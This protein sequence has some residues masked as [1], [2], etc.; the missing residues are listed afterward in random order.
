MVGTFFLP[1]N[2]SM[3]TGSTLSP[4]VIEPYVRPIDWIDI[5]TV[6]NNEINLLV[7]DGTCTAFIVDIASGTYNID[8]GDGVIETE[9]TSGTTYQHE[10]ALG[11]GQI[12]SEGYTTYKIRIYGATGN[13]TRF[14]IAKHSITNRLQTSPILW[15]V[16]GTLNITSY[17]NAFY[18]STV[19]ARS[20]RECYIPSFQSTTSC[21]STFVN[22]SNLAKITIPNSWGAV[23]TTVSMFNNC[24]NLKG[25][26]LPQSWGLITSTLNMFNNCLILPT[27]NLPVTWGLVTNTA[28]MF[29]NCNGFTSLVLPATWGSITNT[30]SMF[31]ACYCLTSIKMPVSW[32]LISNASSM[33]TNCY[34]LVTA[35]CG[36]DWGTGDLTLTQ[37]F[38]NCY[39]LNAVKLPTTWGNVTNTSYM[40]S[41]CYSLKAI[42]LPSSWGSINA[43]NRM[44]HSCVTLTSILLPSSWGL[45]TTTTYMFYNC[46][47]LTNVD[48]G[49][50]WGAVTTADYMFQSCT[51]LINVK[52]PNSWGNI[53]SIN[54]MFYQCQ[55]LI[56]IKFGTS[57]GVMQLTTNVFY[58]CVNL[59]KETL[60]TTPSAHAGLISVGNM[61][62][63]CSS[64]KII[65]NFE[66]LKSASIGMLNLS[67]IVVNCD[68]LE[69]LNYS[70]LVGKIAVNGAS[71]TYPNRLSSLRLT[72]ASSTF[73]GSS[74]QVNVS[75]TN[76]SK[77]ALVTLFGDLP[78]LTSKTINITGAVGAATL[79]AE[80]RTIAT[81]K[82][83]TIIG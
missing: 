8:W 59:V 45:I 11:G 47:N 9:R 71:V 55:G 13:I 5:S 79:T 60:P 1:T 57:W 31:Y 58:Q 18:N 17:Q 78:S 63:Q 52:L 39:A 83:W 14:R 38:M 75:Y 76:M 73:N 48:C 70:G 34:A 33:F 81:S 41:G 53:A 30:S 19:N 43:T 32:G 25:V 28:N 65:E 61:F 40:F 67:D 27:V 3:I 10:H 68:Y 46:K 29:S 42:I 56:N 24:N 64:L 22:C 54:S 69:S 35:D 15:A 51:T 44:F 12:C 20:L 77:D 36:I 37:I 72:N 50:S 82:G 80:E 2:T 16:F 62:Y 74:P 7:T 66:N 4:S 49:T 6:G 21:H 23:T 26:E